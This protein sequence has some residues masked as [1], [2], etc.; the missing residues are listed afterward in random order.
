[1]FR[2]H[3]LSE[4]VIMSN[5]PLLGSQCDSPCAS[6]PPAFQSGSLC[7]APVL[8]LM[9]HAAQQ[10]AVGIE[11]RRGKMKKALSRQQLATNRVTA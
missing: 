5:S 10:A 3:E 6:Q 1:V 9:A 7:E 4:E 2:P 8:S 11:A